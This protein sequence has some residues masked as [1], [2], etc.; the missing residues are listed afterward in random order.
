MVPIS[1]TVWSQRGRI[2]THQLQRPV[3]D[4]EHGALHADLVGGKGSAEGSTNAPADRA[5]HALCVVLAVGRE[6]HWEHAKGRRAHVAE[7]D[8]AVAEPRRHPWPEPVLENCSSAGFCRRGEDQPAGDLVGNV[9]GALLRQQGD[10]SRH[11]VTHIR[12]GVLCRA[13]LCRVRVKLDRH[14]EA[15]GEAASVGVALH[16]SDVENKVR[17]LD[18]ILYRVQRVVTP[19]PPREG[20]RLLVQ[21]RLGRD[22]YGRQREPTQTHSKRQALRSW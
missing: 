16:R 11:N 22:G 13:N 9:G 17:P 14:A 6:R 8:I 4:K 7:E 3:T 12:P 15:E 2:C 5:P 18:Q 10:E 19:V 21:E 20:S 1:W